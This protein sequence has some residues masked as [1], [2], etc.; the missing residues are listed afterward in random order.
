[1]LDL[2]EEGLDPI[3]LIKGVRLE[4][5]ELGQELG[6][7]E[8]DLLN[9][10]RMPCGRKEVCKRA[11]PFWGDNPALAELVEQRVESVYQS[12]VVFLEE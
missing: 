12:G 7:F 8:L 4:C 5:F 11:S 10:H 6:V 1:M 3:L 9:V 2:E